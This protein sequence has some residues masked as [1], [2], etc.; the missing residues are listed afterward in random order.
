MSKGKEGKPHIGIYGKRN[1]GKS[2]LINKIANQDISIVADY[3]GTTTDPVKRSFEITGF[4]PVVLIDTAGI[5]DR[6]DVGILRT[7]KS[8]KTLDHID[9]AIIVLSDNFID[10]EETELIQTIINKHI[11]YFFVHNKSDKERLNQEFKSKIEKEFNVPIVDFSCAKDPTANKIISIIKTEIPEYSW[12]QLSMLEG[13]ISK[14]DLVLLITPID[15]A[16]PQGRLI[17]PQ[18]QTIRD[19]LD[20]ECVAIILKE[21]ELEAFLKNNQVSPALAIT[22]SQ[23]FSL[24]DSLIPKHIPL[25]SFSILLARHKGDFESYLKGAERVSELIDGDKILILESCSH[26]VTCEDIGRVKIPTWLKDFTGKALEFEVVTGLDN[27]PGQI[28][29]YAL[30]VQCGG[31]VITGRQLLNRLRP[32]I[33]AGVPVINYGMLIAYL[34]GIYDRALEPFL[35]K[36]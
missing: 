28:K 26:H 35:K 27:I 34:H 7:S 12:K 2:S 19:V 36:R 29:D 23:I 22:D 24:A 21:T 13:I 5:D 16:A 3:P 4:G 32:A 10:K 31:C 30:V 11:P 20:N 18:V 1:A 33:S 17:L 25:T 8:I 14:N 6:G 15:I 9:L